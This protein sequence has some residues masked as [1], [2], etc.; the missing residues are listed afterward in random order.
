MPMPGVVLRLEVVPLLDDWGR[1]ED[2]WRAAFHLAWAAFAAGTIPVGAVI[3][4]ETGR[5][6]AAGRNRV[7][8]DAAPAGQLAATRLA[9]AELNALAQLSN[10]RRWDTCTLYTTLEP[11]PLCVTATSLASVG[12]ILF[13]GTDP[14]SGGSALIDADLV[15]P[16]PLGVT[17]EGPLESSLE[18]LAT[19]LHLAFFLSR[20]TG[21]SSPLIET[22]RDRR[23]EVLPLAATLIGL[24]QTADFEDALVALD[25]SV[26]SASKLGCTG[27]RDPGHSV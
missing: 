24:R 10:S 21:N 1:T 17:I 27:V 15:T 14:Y 9:H 13:A 5:I 3:V 25:G 6:A 4:D 18:S 8:D 19:A 23:P 20:D 26:R 22:Y 11:C 12:R 16:R 7:F 2:S